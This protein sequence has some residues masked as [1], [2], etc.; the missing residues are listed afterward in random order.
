MERGGVVQ[1][2]PLP[3]SPPT[4]AAVN[5]NRFLAN[6]NLVDALSAAVHYLPDSFPTILTQSHSAISPSPSTP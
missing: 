1:R 5:T 4:A 2:L 3:A 6:R